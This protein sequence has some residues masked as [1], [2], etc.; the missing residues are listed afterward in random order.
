MIYSLVTYW[1]SWETNPYIVIK[2]RLSV[3]GG[4]WDVDAQMILWYLDDHVAALPFLEILLIHAEPLIIK[5]FCPDKM[6]WVAFSGGVAPSPFSAIPGCHDGDFICLI[7]HEVNSQNSLMTSTRYSV[8]LRLR[9]RRRS[10]LPWIR[11]GV[12]NRR[13]TS[14]LSRQAA[15]PGAAVILFMNRSIGQ[16]HP[17]SAIDIVRVVSHRFW[18]NRKHSI[19]PVGPTRAAQRR[20]G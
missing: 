7:W 6:I 20:A 11:V 1:Y 10:L 3:E 15:L 17:A 9:C 13:I 18:W 4:E 12:S 14:G 8:S 5:P 2:T 16:G 19:P